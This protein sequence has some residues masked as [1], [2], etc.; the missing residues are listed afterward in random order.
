MK[1]LACLSLS[2]TKTLEWQIINF[3]AASL[4]SFP[5]CLSP[6]RN[7]F[8]I[9][10]SCIV[11]ISASSAFLCKGTCHQKLKYSTVC[12]LWYWSLWHMSKVY[13][14]SGQSCEFEQSNWVTRLSQLWLQKYNVISRMVTLFVCSPHP[15]DEQT[16]MDNCTESW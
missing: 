11:S 1:L 12:N 5:P 4:S 2:A 13:Q 8:N 15:V 16:A 6:S 7:L 3:L 10:V 9:L 14:K